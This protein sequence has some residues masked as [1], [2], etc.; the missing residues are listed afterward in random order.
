MVQ[1]PA[2]QFMHA[3]YIGKLTMLVL[4]EARMAMPV[5]LLLLV[6]TPPFFIPMR[7]GLPDFR[8]QDVLPD[9]S[10]KLTP[11][12]QSSGY[13]TRIKGAM[14]VISTMM[15]VMQIGCVAIAR[16][17]VFDLVSAAWGGPPPEGVLLCA[18]LATAALAVTPLVYRWYPNSVV[19]EPL[20]SPLSFVVLMLTL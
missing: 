10:R 13:Q 8:S 5:S 2:Y 6:A 19:C 17:A 18:L 11:F 15:F 14:A 1:W 4:P 16:L 12:E 9:P 3:L 20:V 7:D